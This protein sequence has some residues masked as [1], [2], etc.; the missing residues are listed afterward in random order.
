MANELQE[1]G[2]HVVYG[3]VGYKTH[4]KMCMVVRRE[5]RILRRYVHLGTGNYHS[6]TSRIYTDYGLFTCDQDIGLDVNRLFLQLTGLGRAGKLKKLLQSPFTLHKR[7]LELI[8]VEARNVLAAKEAR[9]ILKM[10]ALVDPDL[11]RALYRASQAG[12]K[13]DLVIRG[14]CCLR[15]GIKGVSENIQ[16]RSIIGRFLEHTRVFYFGHG[17]EEL[18]YCSSADWMP[19]NMHNRV[20]VCFPIEEKRPREQVLTYGLYNYLSDNSQSWIMQPDGSYRRSRPGNA[21]PRS[22]Q[23]Q[24]LDY[25]C[26]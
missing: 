24:A 16:V 1:A 18:L 6:R 8:E 4:A 5:G 23:L 9:I 20:E 3:I 7:L 2:A 15:P 19:R 26:N 25:F 14:I 17:G 13:I 10:N 12:V 11:I 21:K 22:A